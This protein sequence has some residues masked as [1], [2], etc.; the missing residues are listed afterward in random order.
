METAIQC[1]SDNASY[2]RV[3]PLLLGIVE[4]EEMYPLTT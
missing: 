2:E 4:S 1:L 3:M